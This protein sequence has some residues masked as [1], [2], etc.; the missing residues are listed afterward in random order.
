[1]AFFLR[2]S[3]T[4]RMGGGIDATGNRKREPDSLTGAR[5][6][7][8]AL[9]PGAWTRELWAQACRRGDTGPLT[10]EQRGP[11]A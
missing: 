2:M 3:G 9:A 8:G 11:A 4:E 7:G 10:G 6:T 1:M 5:G